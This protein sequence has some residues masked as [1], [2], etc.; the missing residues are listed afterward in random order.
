MQCPCRWQATG[1]GIK[2]LCTGWFYLR[3]DNPAALCRFLNRALPGTTSSYVSPCAL[4]M[5]PPEADL[6]LLEFTFNDAERSHEGQ[7][8]D[9]PTRYVPVHGQHGGALPSNQATA[10]VVCHEAHSMTARRWVPAQAALGVVKCCITCTCPGMQIKLGTLA[11]LSTSIQCHLWF[12][13]LVPAL[14]RLH[15][16]LLVTQSD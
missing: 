2:N 1:R 5:V 4:Q 10:E 8:P 6:V 9:D 13:A 12:F 7:S 15:P 3:R 14:E 11:L 16:S